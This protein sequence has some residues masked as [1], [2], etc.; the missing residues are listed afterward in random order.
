MACR[1]SK[2]SLGEQQAVNYRSHAPAA[3]T[4]EVVAFLQLKTLI[5]NPFDH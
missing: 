1:L 3:P 4:S 2:E 5:L